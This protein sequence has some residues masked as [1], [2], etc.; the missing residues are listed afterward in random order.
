MKMRALTFVRN[1]A[2][3]RAFEMRE[4]DAPVP[5]PGQALIRVDA[6]GINFAD[7]MATQGLYPSAPPRPCVLGYD[8]AGT[9]TQVGP[10]VPAHWVGQRVFALTRFG[11]YAEYA[12]ADLRALSILPPEFSIAQGTALATQLATAVIASEIATQVFAGEKALVLAGAGGVGLG[13]T[14]LLSHRGVEVISVVSRSSKV[15]A[16]RD[17]G[18]REVRVSA[19]PSVWAKADEKFDVIFDSVG[20]R[21]WKALRPH[22]APGGRYVGLGAADLVSSKLKILSWWPT[23]PIPWMEASQSLVG[24]NLLTLADHKIELLAEAFRRV[25]QYIQAGVI[26]PSSVRATAYPV[27]RFGEAFGALQ[28]RTAVGK[29]V[30]TW[31]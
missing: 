13:L 31:K 2:P 20:A 15:Q 10:D 7:L 16:A 29:L 18:A 19:D 8:V 26:T 21:A 6:S 30:L 24:V 27:E 23:H 12:L 1:A 9:V 14:R 11:G 5:G 25:N 3:D 28:A 22:L 4:Q 17:A